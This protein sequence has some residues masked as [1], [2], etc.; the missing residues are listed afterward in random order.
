MNNG[1]VA[2]KDPGSELVWVKSRYPVLNLGLAHT[3][4]GA[5][6]VHH[7]EDPP[8]SD[9]CHYVLVCADSRE[10]LF[11]SL[12]FARERYSEAKLVIF[13]LT[14]DLA[15]AREALRSGARG[16]IHGA[17]HPGQV[18]QAMYAVRKGE[19]AAPRELLGFLFQ[20]ANTANTKV[21]TN[22][23][24]EVVELAVG[25]LSNLQI[26]QKLYLSESSVKQ[27]LRAAFKLLG[28]KS[29]TEAARVF[30]DS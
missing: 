16:F 30:R 21:L 7:G 15:L 29:R 3:L 19:L 14:M 8:D 13:S 27:H 28:V 9:A 11:S 4:Q 17:M 18:L 2:S 12:E 5:F 25:G 6:R 24:Q 26:A 23:Q 1:A 22:R 10:D 20:D